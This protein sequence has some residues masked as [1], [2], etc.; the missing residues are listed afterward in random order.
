MGRRRDISEFVTRARR[1][2]CPEERRLSKRDIGRVANTRPRVS[3]EATLDSTRHLPAPSRILGR[4]WSALWPEAP[5]NQRS[6]PEKNKSSHYSRVPGNMDREMM[7]K[8]KEKEEEEEERKGWEGKGEEPALSI[9]LVADEIT[10]CNSTVRRRILIPAINL[11]GSPR[12]PG[13]SRSCLPPP[14][15][16]YSLSLSS[17]LFFLF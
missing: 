1:L 2:S 16:L 7:K 6:Q 12:I 14:P 17:P 11:V 15:P 8:K 3:E 13:P 4:L 5:L 9:C 10:F